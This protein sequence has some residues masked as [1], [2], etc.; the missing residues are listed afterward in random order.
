[1]TGCTNRAFKLTSDKATED[2]KYALESWVLGKLTYVE[3]RA[4]WARF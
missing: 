1:M 2:L 4:I 3:N